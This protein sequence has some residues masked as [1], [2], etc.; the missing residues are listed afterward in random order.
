MPKASPLKASRLRASTSS[1]VSKPITHRVPDQTHDYRLDPIPYPALKTEQGVFTTPPYSG[2]IKGAWRFKDEAA[3]KESSE[4]IWGMF[5]SYMRVYP[6]VHV[7]AVGRADK[8]ERRT[9]S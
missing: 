8:T 6:L 3:A 7:L 5:R 9:I 1:T 2:E 4:V